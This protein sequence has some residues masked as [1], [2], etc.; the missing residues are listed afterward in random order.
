MIRSSISQGRDQAPVAEHERAP[1]VLQLHIAT[2]RIARGVLLRQFPERRPGADVAPF[3]FRRNHRCI[4]GALHHGAI[5]GFGRAGEEC[6]PAQPEESEVVGRA[7]DR[8]ARGC[9]DVGPVA[10]ELLQQVSCA[11]REHAAVPIHVPGGDHR[12]CLVL[13]WFF[14]KTR[15]AE[16]A[17]VAWQGIA[18]L[19]V[20]K[21]AVGAR[22]RNAESQKHPGRGNSGGTAHGTVECRFA[23]DRVVRGKYQ[24]DRIVLFMEQCGDRDRCRGAAALGLEHDA[25][26]D[27]D[28]R[29]LILHQETV[30]FVADDQRLRAIRRLLRAQ[31]RVLQQRA[32]GHE[33]QE[34]LGQQ[35]ARQRPEAAARAAAQNHGDYLPGHQVI[36]GP[37]AP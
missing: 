24:Q 11:E 16:C 30:R 34:L 4:G 13:G 6:F 33:R 7:R 32:P 22:R 14:H 8:R 15:D 21:T 2:C 12:A 9:Q 37:K 25:R 18:A 10:A 3:E 29:E 20:A 5:D 28:F 36:L 19:D 23:A 35:L 27:A 26:G 17:T 31:R 1:R